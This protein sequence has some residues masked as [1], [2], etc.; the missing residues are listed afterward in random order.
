MVETE[1]ISYFISFL[2]ISLFVFRL[3]V[4]HFSE[5]QLD[6]YEYYRRSGFSRS[7]MKK[8]GLT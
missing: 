4:S 5:D 8:V 7:T 2:V 3:L 6:R 1:L